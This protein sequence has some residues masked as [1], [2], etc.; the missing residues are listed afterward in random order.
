MKRIHQS[1]AEIARENLIARK[2]PAWIICSKIRKFTIDLLIRQRVIREPL[3]APVAN[4]GLDEPFAASGGPSL[5][6]TS[7]RMLDVEADG[8]PVPAAP[9]FQKSTGEESMS[10]SLSRNAHAF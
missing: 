10:T 9:T 5:P 4:R 1:Q 7:T 6:L 8:R 2:Y 3:E